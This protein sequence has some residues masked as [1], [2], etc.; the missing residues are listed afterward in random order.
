MYKTESHLDRLKKIKSIGVSGDMEVNA[1]TLINEYLAWFSTGQPSH[2]TLKVR[3]NHLAALAA[4]HPDLLA[5]TGEDL[6]RH[7]GNPHWAQQTKKSHRSTLRSFYGWAYRYEYIAKDPSADLRPIKIPVG[8]PRPA[9]EANVEAAIANA[10]ATDQVM[11]LLAAYAGLRRNEIATLRQS[12]VEGNRLRVT[13]KG[14]RTRLV[15]IHPKLAE[16][17][18]QQLQRA[19]GHEWVFP[20]PV[21][22]NCER[23]ISPDY[24]SKTLKRL[25][26]GELTAHT[27]RHRFATKA[28]QGTKDIRAVQELLGHSS[29]STTAIYTLVEDDQLASAVGMIA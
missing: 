2:G 16:P 22:Y 28:Y 18:A 6:Q 8:R 26:G 11:V 19:K 24:V 4:K 15:P 12:N 21:K 7:L 29:P 17:L 20:S 5:V 9:P 27:L 13:G 25:L 3:S 1:V 23:H 14:G 10:T